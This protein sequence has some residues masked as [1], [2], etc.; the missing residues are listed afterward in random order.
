[1]YAP[2]FSSEGLN[3]PLRFLSLFQS[4]LERSSDGPAE[5]IAI[6]AQSA[7]CYFASVEIFV[8]LLFFLLDELY[9]LV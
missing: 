2:F 1:L 4:F 6:D 8:V 9:D 5:G 3:R 7:F